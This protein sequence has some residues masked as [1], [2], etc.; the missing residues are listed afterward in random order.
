MQSAA[1]LRWHI[2][3]APSGRSRLE[4]ASDG[5]ETRRDTLASVADGVSDRPC[6]HVRVR[7]TDRPYVEDTAIGAVHAVPY[8]YVAFAYRGQEQVRR[9]HALLRSIQRELRCER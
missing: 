3:T 6:S 9:Q 5:R 7:R 8:R 1:L 4:P 2:P